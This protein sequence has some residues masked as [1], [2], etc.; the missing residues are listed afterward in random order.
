MFKIPL[1]F[2]IMQVVKCLALEHSFT[3]Q[4]VMLFTPYVEIKKKKIC[5]VF[6]GL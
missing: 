5:S 4:D 6:S 2:V 1:T 3:Q